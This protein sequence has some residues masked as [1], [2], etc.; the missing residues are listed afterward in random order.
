ML[1][2]D[3]AATAG[4]DLV[5]LATALAF[6]APGTFGGIVLRG[7]F[8]PV[9]DAGL[10]ELQG[11][12]RMPFGADRTA[13]LGGIDLAATLRA[14]TPTHASGLLERLGGPLIVPSAERMEPGTA[15]ILAQ[16]L[17]GDGPAAPQPILALDEGEGDDPLLD[18]RLS[19]RLAFTLPSDIDLAPP[20]PLPA[21][22]RDVDASDELVGALSSLALAAGRTS[23]RAAVH[24]VAAA[25]AIA[26]LHGRDAID[27]VDAG[28]AIALVIG[29]LAPPPPPPEPDEQTPA[30]PP[31]DAETPDTGDD[32][33]APPE[34]G[35]KPD[36]DEDKTGGSTED[37]VVDAVATVIDAAALAGLRTTAR[38]GGLQGR[39][40]QKT[41]GMRG[42]P[43]SVRQGAPGRNGRLALVE[44]L[45]AAAPWQRVRGANEGRLSVRM[46]DLRIRRTIAKAGTLTIFCVDASGSQAFARMA[47][48]KGAV[49]TLLARAYVRRDTVAL[50][51]F[52]GTGADVLLPPT[53]SLTRTKRALAALPGGGGTPL[54]AGLEAAYRIA[55]SA[56]R[57][58]R[59]PTLVCL[60]DA[61]ANVT[62]SG[63]GGRAQAG[64]DARTLARAIRAAGIAALVIDTGARPGASARTLADA[65]GARYMPLGRASAQA[66]AAAASALAVP[67]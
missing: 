52:R 10:A 59:E 27:D 41:A 31:D 67:A 33:D 9:R 49:E 1:R 5:G 45:T 25:K 3:P 29:Q 19:E 18:P 38:R 37:K 7:P 4:L 15:S 50:I 63:E 43:S 64:E 6:G 54:A 24:L 57:D 28:T 65:M 55:A 36:G 62:L 51:A 22:W 47:E 46:E 58:G 23:M 20:H 66:I 48:A 2:P 12:V 35:D 44:T 32:T 34:P 14:G 16:F 11:A 30:D 26:A 42:R 8:S 13:L 21:G 53:S 60:T 17:D 61:R 39:M 40:G 56:Q